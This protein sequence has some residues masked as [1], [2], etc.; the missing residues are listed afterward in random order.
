MKKLAL[1]L[2]AAMLLPALVACGGD[3]DTGAADTTAA[4]TAAETTA[5]E[6]EEE[7]ITDD[8]PK[9]LNYNGYEFKL[10]SRYAPIYFNY[11]VGA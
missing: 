6:T 11:T 7:R 1:I 2:L 3:A 9:D 10:H 5:A 4:D 8:L